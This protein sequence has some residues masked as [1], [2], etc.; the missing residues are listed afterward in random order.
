MLKSLTQTKADKGYDENYIIV[1][2]SIIKHYLAKCYVIRRYLTKTL[3]M[4]HHQIGITV[5]SNYNSL[6]F[7]KV[8][9]KQNL[10]YLFIMNK[11]DKKCEFLKFAVNK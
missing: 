6:K 9:S 11:N 4:S 1:S 3:Q 5:L 8:Y 7:T 2:T 10:V